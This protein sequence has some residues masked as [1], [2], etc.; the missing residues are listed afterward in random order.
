MLNNNNPLTEV[1]KADFCINVSFQ[2]MG[3]LFNFLKQNQIKLAKIK[4]VD[5]ILLPE[6]KE[7]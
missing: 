2:L 4:V 7:N 5:N 1:R 6:K 3:Q